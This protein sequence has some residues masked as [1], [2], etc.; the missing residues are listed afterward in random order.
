MDQL[1]IAQAHLAHGR[2]EQAVAILE[3]AMRSG[4]AVAATEL[5]VW[6][7]RGDA[8]ARDLSRARTYLRRAVEIGHADS[9]LLEIALI[10]SGSGDVPDWRKALSLLREA[11]ASDPV[12]AHHLTLIKAM[13]VDGEGSPIQSIQ[14]EVLSRS[15]YIARFPRAL[16]KDECEH[17]AQIAS[18]TMA[19]SLVVDPATGRN[20]AHPIRSSDG[21]VIGPTR[22]TLVIGALNR[23]LARLSGTSVEQGEPLSIL[24]YGPGQEY[25]PHVDSLPTTHNQRIITAITYLNDGFAGGETRF[26]GLDLTIRPSAGDVLLFHNVTADGRVDPATRHA[27]LPVRSGVKWIATRWI[28]QHRYDPWTYREGQ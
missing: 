19:P 5:A 24:R 20:A 14:P 15:P 26:D 4:D 6:H 17:I 9:A 22:E 2:T 12:A 8:I 13:R 27:G 1:A 23:R 10:A 18:P 11:A 16:S 7:L 25:R 3:T 21:T 28:R